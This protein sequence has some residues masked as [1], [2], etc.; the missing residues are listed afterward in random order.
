M[1]SSFLTTLAVVACAL[2]PSVNGYP[3]IEKLA[4]TFPKSRLG[5]RGLD[6][7]TRQTTWSPSQ[8]IDITGDHAWQAPKPGDR[9]L[10]AFYSRMNNDRWEEN[11]TVG[12]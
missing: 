7:E 5:R 11:L 6:L 8:L 4:V 2:Y 3:H 9:Y 12:R 10:L 1:L